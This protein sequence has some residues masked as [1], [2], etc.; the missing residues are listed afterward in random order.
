MVLDTRERKI[1]DIGW[2]FERRIKETTSKKLFGILL[3]NVGDM[4]AMFDTLFSPFW[5]NMKKKS[6]PDT[7]LVA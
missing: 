2:M 6:V 5:C 4:L 7:N 3:N 1:V